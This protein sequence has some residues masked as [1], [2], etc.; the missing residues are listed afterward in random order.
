MATLLRSKQLQEVDKPWIAKLLS[1][2]CIIIYS[3]NS[4]LIVNSTNVANCVRFNSVANSKWLSVNIRRDEVDV[5]IYHNH[6]TW[7]EHLF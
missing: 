1:C 3:L 2:I 4:K 5:N 6:E 7:G